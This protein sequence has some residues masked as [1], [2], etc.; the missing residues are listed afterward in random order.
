MY[1]EDVEKLMKFNSEEMRT[2]R[3]Y[4]VKVRKEQEKEAFDE[5]L[6]KN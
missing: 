6:S 3:A 2:L 5:F 1:P 4:Q